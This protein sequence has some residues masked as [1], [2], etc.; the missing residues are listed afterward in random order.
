MLCV[1]GF[2]ARVRVV[3]ASVAAVF[4]RGVVVASCLVAVADE[5]VRCGL[6]SECS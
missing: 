6:V 4:G 3:V 1:D 2:R 5:F